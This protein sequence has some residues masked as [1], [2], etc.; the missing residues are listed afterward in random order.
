MML[1]VVSG[2]IGSTDVFKNINMT[3]F[4]V[5]LFL[6]V[7][8]AVLFFGDFY[9]PVN[10]WTGLVTVIEMLTRKN[11]SGRASY[12][13]RLGH[14]PGLVLYMSLIALELF[15]HVKPLGLSVALVVYSLVM[16]VGSWIYGKE[17]WIAHAEVFGILC[18]L[19][20]MM[21]VRA[22]GGNARIRLPMFRI[23][24]EY[25]RDFGLILFVLFMLSSTAFD[26]I[27]ETVPWMNLYWTIVYPYISWVD[28]LWGAAGQNRYVAS[29]TL[30]GAWQWVA[31]FVSPLLYF[32]VFAVF[33]RFSSITGRSKL[34]VRD[35]LARFTL[36]LLPIAFVYHVSH[37]FLLVVMQGPQLIKLVSD[38]FG[39]GW[40]LLGTATW[41]IPPV[42]LDVETIWHAQVALIIVGHVASVV[43]AHFEALRS[44]DTPRQATLSQV[45]ML[46]LM[47]LFTASGLWILSLPISPSS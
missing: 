15:G 8:Y 6:V 44:F 20:G 32:F 26:G 14:F 33:L 11:F 31:L 12:P 21:S 10:P 37:Y 4:W 17:T 5:V 2:L 45:P 47:V 29:T 42:N 27:H 24:E 46:G 28:T 38:P 35:L 34:S 40:N 7:P 30:Y 36:C 22:G 23:S 25:R 41:R 39:F 43:I 18:R 3:L 16:T 13:N 9:A 1:C 19:V